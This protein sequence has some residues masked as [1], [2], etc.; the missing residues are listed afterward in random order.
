M[1]CRHLQDCKP[2]SANSC[3]QVYPPYLNCHNQ[4]IL[5]FSA[6][7]HPRFLGYL[8]DTVAKHPCPVLWD[9]YSH[10]QQHRH[11][12][13]SILCIWSLFCERDLNIVVFSA[14]GVPSSIGV[15]LTL[16]ILTPLCLLL[17]RWALCKQAR[18]TTMGL[19]VLPGFHVQAFSLRDWQGRVLSVLWQTWCV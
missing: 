9:R 11:I 18:P 2:L 19:W 15:L 14:G 17:C 16:T 1:C 5:T 7:P 13:R 8:L 6:C 3:C 4:I 10:F 12:L